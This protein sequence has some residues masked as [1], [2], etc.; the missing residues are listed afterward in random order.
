MINANIGAWLGGM[1]GLK[2][3]VAAVDFVLNSNL[4]D[5]AIYFNSNKYSKAKGY[6]SFDMPDDQEGQWMS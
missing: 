6:V 1:W 2:T 3:N 5:I 4:I